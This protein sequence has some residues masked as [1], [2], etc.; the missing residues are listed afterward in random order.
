MARVGSV[1]VIG[2]FQPFHW[3]HFEYLIEAALLGEALVVGI[4]NPSRAE[5]RVTEADLDRSTEKSNPFSF[6]QRS[7]MI[8]RSLELAAPHLNVR[9]RSCDLTSPQLLRKSLGVCDLVALTVYDEWGAEKE[10]I[11][12]DAGYDVV[13][14]WERT[15]KVTTGHD[16]RRRLTQKLPW[17]HLVPRGTAEVLRQAIEYPR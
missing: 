17:D 11:A 10:A 3:G 13:V 15:Q 6:G 1:A 16:I 14:L 7:R 12:R 5:R 8:S 2:R 9:I 4:A